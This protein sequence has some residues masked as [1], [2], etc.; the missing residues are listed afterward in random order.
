MPRPADAVDLAGDELRDV[1]A[2]VV[3][4]G[5]VAPVSATSVGK[6]SSELTIS[7][8]TRPGRIRAGQR[9]IAGTRTPPSSHENLPPLH[10][11]AE[12]GPAAG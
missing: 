5:S 12:P 6:R 3:R 7:F 9:M 8:T 11:P 10:G 4:G 2:V 1:L